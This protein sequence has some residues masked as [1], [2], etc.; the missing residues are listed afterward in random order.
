MT[1]CWLAET[2][3]AINPKGQVGPCCRNSGKTNDIKLQSRTLAQVFTDERLQI[4]RD[5]LKNG[6]QIKECSKCWFEE[7]NSNRKSM[8]QYSNEG[9]DFSLLENLQGAD[10]IHSLEIAFSN[11][12][13]YRCRHCSS[14]SSSKWYKEDILLGRPV[15]EKSLLEPDIE[16]FKIEELTNLNYVKLLG[17]EPL[18]NKNHDKFLKKLDE[19]GIL[20]NISLEYVTN[21]SVWPSSEIIDLWKKAKNLRVI[22]SLDDVEEQFNY[23]RTDGNFETVKKNLNN[24]T[25]LYLEN[26]KKVL[27]GLHCVVNVLNL[28]RMSYIVKYMDY[29]FPHWQYTFDRVKT[30]EFLRTSQWSNHYGQIQIDELEIIKSKTFFNGAKKRNLQN[31]INIISHECVNNHT[32]LTEFFKINDM[33]DKSRNTNCLEVH[34]YMEKHRGVNLSMITPNINKTFYR[35]EDV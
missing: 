26:R 13:N 11:H 28:R 19:M 9:K 16:A 32:D 29:N 22:I 1:R 18:I 23:F 2:H 14:L 21:G 6:V 31:L 35:I 8:R 25:K 12:C 34:S 10:L 30:P 20:Q 15:T 27:L 7:K 17:G 3:L 33:L 5:N 24:F 4:I